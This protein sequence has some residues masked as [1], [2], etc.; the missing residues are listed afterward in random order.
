[1]FAGLDIIGVELPPSNDQLFELL[2]V[3]NERLQHIWRREVTSSS[4]MIGTQDLTVEELLFLNV[5]VLQG[6]YL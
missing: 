4:L 3:G 2:F 6:E 5:E 1:M